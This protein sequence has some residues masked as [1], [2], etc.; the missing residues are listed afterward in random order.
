MFHNFSTK[1]PLQHAVQVENSITV[2]VN[3]QIM[4]TFH[5]FYAHNTAG[6]ATIARDFHAFGYI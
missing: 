2:K 6:Q 4:Q 5:S 1:N 3:F